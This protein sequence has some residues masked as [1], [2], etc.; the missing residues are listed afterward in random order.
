ME[1]QGRKL[2]KS[3]QQSRAGSNPGMA[4]QCEVK[5]VSCEGIKAKI[6]YLV[7]IDCFQTF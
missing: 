5:Q 6:N 7:L 3:H 1:T 2:W 4:C